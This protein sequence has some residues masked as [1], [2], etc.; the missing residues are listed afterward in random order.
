MVSFSSLNLFITASL[1]ALNLTLITVTELKVSVTH[2]F[3]FLFAYFVI[4]L[5]ET[6]HFWQ[7]A[8]GSNWILL[9]PLTA[10]LVA[11]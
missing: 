1:T 5:L 9:P 7:S 4:F 11:H 2:G 6:E 8:V 10:C 3:F